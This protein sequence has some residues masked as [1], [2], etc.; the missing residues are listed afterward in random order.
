MGLGLWKLGWPG[1][2]VA[3][4]FPG[5]LLL[6]GLGLAPRLDF[7]GLGCR[8]TS[9]IMDAL[10]YEYI[11][12]YGRESGHLEGICKESGFLIFLL[13]SSNLQAGLDLGYTSMSSI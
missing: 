13:G 10:V 12:A 5:I 11:L 9:K 1:S 2:Q 3:G 6:R 7:F 4:I 8:W